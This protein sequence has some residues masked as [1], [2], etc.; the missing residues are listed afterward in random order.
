MPD[1]KFILILGGARSGKSSF[2]ERLACLSGES[3]AYVAT[4]AAWDEEMRHRIAAHQQQ[5]PAHWATVEEELWVKQAVGDLHGKYPVVL[6]DCLTLL[7]TNMLLNPGFA[8]SGS[9]TPQ[10]QEKMILGELEQLGRACRSFA[11]TVIMVSNEVGQGLVPDNPLGRQYRDVA[12]RANQ[13]MASLAHE[14]YLVVAGIP[15]EIKELGARVS[16]KL[17]MVKS[18]D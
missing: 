7:V 9:L 8:G 10:E 16:D 4:A 13:L 3:V 14:V 12:G 17:G 11:G 2:A 18:N 1:N 6:I 15:V 5:R